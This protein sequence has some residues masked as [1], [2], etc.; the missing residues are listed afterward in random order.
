[1][2][3]TSLSG[4][5]LGWQ[6]SRRQWADER[7]SPLQFPEHRTKSRIIVNPEGQTEGPRTA[8]TFGRRNPVLD[9]TADIHM[10]ESGIR[11]DGGHKVE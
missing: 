5:R 6:Q 4:C 7:R 9:T 1:M 2:E 8:I 10:V 3:E 11:H